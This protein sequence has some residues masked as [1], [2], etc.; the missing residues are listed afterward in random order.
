MAREQPVNLF[1]YSAR[2]E[3]LPAW[4]EGMQMARQMTRIVGM[5]PQ[6]LVGGREDSDGDS[7]D[8]DGDSDDDS[9]RPGG[10]NCG[11]S[12]HDSGQD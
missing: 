3:Q 2:G 5:A 10:G 1:E 8:D 11:Q 12:R 7:D 4:K 6:E 9:D